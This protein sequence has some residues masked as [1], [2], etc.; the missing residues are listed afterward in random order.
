MVRGKIKKREKLTAADFFRQVA[1]R[2]D[3]GK[4]LIHSFTK[5]A[6]GAAN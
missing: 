6:A 3:S 1:G 2:Y 4:P 5:E